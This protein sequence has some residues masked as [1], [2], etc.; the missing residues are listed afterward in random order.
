MRRRYRLLTFQ[1]GSGQYLSLVVEWQDV[2]GAWHSKT[3]NSYGLATQEAMA[4]AQADLQD[5]ERLASDATAPVPIG[6]INDAIWA[7]FLSAAG[8]PLVGLTLGPLLAI[9]DLIH[10]GSYLISNTSGNLAQKVNVTQPNMPAPERAQFI[11]WLQQFSGGDQALIL[12]Y[13]W[14]FQP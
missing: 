11:Q 13:Q 14:R 7:G 5:L 12:A 8:N 3:V 2:H 10:L 4:Q 6:T 9:R 1:K